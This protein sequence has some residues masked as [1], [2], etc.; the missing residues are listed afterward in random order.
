MSEQCEILHNLFNSVKRYNYKTGFEGIP[1]NGIYIMFES[2]EKAHG[3]DRI[4]RIGTH[5]GNNQLQSR[6]RQHFLNESKNRSIFRKNIGR[7]LLAEREYSDKWEYDIT[8]RENKAKYL[9]L[10]DLEFEKI[11]EKQISEY[12]R[13]NL[14]FAIIPLVDKTNRLRIEV[15]L[16]STISL[17]TECKA[18]VLWLGMKSPKNKIRESGLWQVNELWG[19]PLSEQELKI[20]EK[21]IVIKW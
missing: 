1:K 19:E 13:K 2:G 15:G 11:I 8:S 16:I 14:S 4:V 7:C 6:I 3:G 17:C 20:I 18:S 10:L 5:T 12:I 21:A 9:S